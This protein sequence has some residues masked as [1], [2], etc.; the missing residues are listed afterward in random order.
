MEKHVPA[1][2]NFTR[3]MEPKK[4]PDGLL[5]FL[6]GDCYNKLGLIDKAMDD[7]TKSAELNP[8]GRPF[9]GQALSRLPPSSWVGQPTIGRPFYGQA[10]GQ[11]QLTWRPSAGS[12]QSEGSR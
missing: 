12:P 11:L 8:K 9:Y 10:K 5:L 1:A 7:Y 3:A 2:V 6:R 4:K